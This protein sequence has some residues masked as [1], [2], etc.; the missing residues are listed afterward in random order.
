M[1][2]DILRP[3]SCATKCDLRGI[4][5]GKGLVYRLATLSRR[6]A[7][8]ILGCL[9]AALAADG[10]KDIFSR[11]MMPLLRDAATERG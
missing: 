1:S 2:R 10:G 5:F 9:P 7:R 11:S 6:G 4:D 3:G 8:V